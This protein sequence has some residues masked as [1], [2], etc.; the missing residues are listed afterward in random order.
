MKQKLRIVR[1]VRA[2]GT[3]LAV[4][5]LVIVM[6]SGIGAIALNAASY[7]VASAG[8]I[9]QGGDASAIAQ[10]GIVVGRC[11]MCEGLDGIVVLMQSRRENLGT[12]PQFTMT[13]AQLEAGLPPGTKLFASPS[14]VEGRGSF[15]HVNPAVPP[16][17]QIKVRLD[18]PRETGSIAGYSM[19]ESVGADSASFCFRTYRMTS[20]GIFTTPAVPPAS[21]TKIQTDHR[22]YVTAGP[23]ECTN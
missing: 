23:I 8:A 22:A 2:R 12:S 9:R 5:M 15:G 4:A 1:K 19:R 16:S 17:Y 14:A 10:A 11:E 6:L 18:R 13:E 21:G 20:T 3:A 7:D